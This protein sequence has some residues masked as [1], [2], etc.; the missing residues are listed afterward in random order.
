MQHTRKRKGERGGEEKDHHKQPATNHQPLFLE[1][2]NITN[3]SPMTK[4]GKERDEKMDITSNSHQ[5]PVL[6]LQINQI[7][8]IPS[9]FSPST[10]QL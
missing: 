2:V 6:T 8:H 10:H 5:Y 9:I 4:E 7:K 1:P 3:Q